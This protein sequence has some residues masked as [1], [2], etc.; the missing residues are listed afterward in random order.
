MKSLTNCSALFKPSSISNREQPSK[1]SKSYLITEQKPKNKLQLSIRKLK[2]NIK[3]PQTDNKTHFTT[4][5]NPSQVSPFYNNNFHYKIYE[6]AIDAFFTFLKETLHNDI[7]NTAK[8]VFYNEITKA[9]D[10]YINYKNKMN[11][12]FSHYNH[13]H[14]SSIGKTLTQ[15]NVYYID[16][17]RCCESGNKSKKKNL[18]LSYDFYSS[19][20]KKHSN[21]N[22]S[23][24]KVHYKYTNDKHTKDNNHINNGNNNSNNNTNKKE[25]KQHSLYTLTK[26]KK[27]LQNKTQSNSK[28]KSHSKEHKKKQNNFVL[29]IKL[30]KKL[31]KE[32]NKIAIGDCCNNNN[33]NNNIN[34]DNISNKKAF[35][36]SNDNKNQNS[37]HTLDA[38]NSNT[39]KKKLK[40]TNNITNINH[41][42]N[43]NNINNTAVVPNINIKLSHNK[44]SNFTL[45]CI[46]NHFNSSSLNNNTNA[47]TTT[48]TNR[49]CI[50]KKTKQ[51]TYSKKNRI[52]KP[53]I[54]INS[55]C[56]EK[57]SPHL[58]CKSCRERKSIQIP[59]D[60]GVPLDNINEK[61]NSEQLREIKS[62][63]DEHLKV[64][65][66]F[67]YEGFLNKESE[68]ESKKS[69][70]GSTTP[71]DDNNSTPSLNNP[72]LCRQLI[73]KRKYDY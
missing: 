60:N 69:F 16:S 22:A 32:H 9:V 59:N 28:S 40:N 4:V 70:E 5:N 36:F 38:Y 1:P 55:N 43:H 10:V 39:S 49:C 23:N 73:Y 42:N 51:Q 68:S 72:N 35:E 54:A 65:F 25:Q 31:N 57:V 71:I 15:V 12:S 8:Q 11:K 14:T 33:I 64:I 45:F 29:N 62:N 44:H 58:P 30:Y 6:I 34:E 17:N 13:K 63:L 26:N 3:Y 37:T 67:S 21:A 19:I 20:K 24:N 27:F 46:N 18:K 66:N 61:Q 7:Y 56:K 47:T 50:E 48:N 41:N 2:P 52:N 53:S